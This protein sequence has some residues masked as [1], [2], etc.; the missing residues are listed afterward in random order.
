[1]CIFVT[2][3]IEELVKFKVNYKTQVAR[4]HQEYVSYK[5]DERDFHDGQLMAK[6]ILSLVFEK[7][8][9]WYT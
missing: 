6:N 1:M 9:T 2:D 8:Q 7:L 3:K 4:I 5:F